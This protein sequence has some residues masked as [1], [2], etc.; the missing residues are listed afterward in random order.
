MTAA[1]WWPSSFDAIENCPLKEP[2]PILSIG[3]GC[4]CHCETEIWERENARPGC[5]SVTW[6]WECDLGETEKRKGGRHLV[7]FLF[8]F[9]PFVRIESVLM[10]MIGYI[11]IAHHGFFT[12]RQCGSR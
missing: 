2:S 9:F 12:Y 3:E 8:S 10:L 7:C 1:D 6:V 5:G 4:L 11:Q